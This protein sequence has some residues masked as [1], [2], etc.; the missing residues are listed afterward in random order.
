MV[1]DPPCR[2]VHPRRDG[3]RARTV[4]VVVRVLAALSI[5]DP[6][7][8]VRRALDQI[9]FQLGESRFSL[10]TVVEGALALVTF[11]WLAH[12][13]R[14]FRGAGQGGLGMA[15]VTGIGGVFIQGAKSKGPVGPGTATWSNW[16]SRKAAASC[17]PDPTIHNRV[18]Q[19]IRSWGPF[20]PKT[21]YFDPSEKPFM[22]NVRFDDL[23]GM[24]ARLRDAGAQVM[25]AEDHQPYGRFGWF[26]DPNGNKVELWEPSTGTP[27]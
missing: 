14:Q 22:V 1:G 13:F 18:E 4:S 7:D 16:R 27:I 23:D 6:I 19:V 11:L 9:G 3:L 2:I 15:R 24:L 20:D 12:L 5:L 21:R 17:L 10:L 25:D 26:I 8:T